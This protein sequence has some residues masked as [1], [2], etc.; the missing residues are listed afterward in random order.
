MATRRYAAARRVFQNGRKNEAKIEKMRS[1]MRPSSFAIR[2]VLQFD[3]DYV[4]PVDLA[5]GIPTT[6]FVPSRSVCFSLSGASQGEIIGVK[7]PIAVEPWITEPVNIY[8][9]LI[10]CVQSKLGMAA[11]VLLHVDSRSRS[12][13]SIYIT[14][15]GFHFLPVPVYIYRSTCTYR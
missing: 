7:L 14:V 10:Q 8:V 11:P 4:V 5:V 9:P 2:V 13:E 6:C 15:S 3:Y 1:V 12:R